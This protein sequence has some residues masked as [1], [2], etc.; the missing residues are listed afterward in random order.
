ML[1][2]PSGHS[3]DINVE[4]KIEMAE[5][6]ITVK[7][8]VVAKSGNLLATLTFQN[9]SDKNVYLDK[10]TSCLLD[11]LTSRVFEIIGQDGAALE[12]VGI[13]VKRKYN[14]DDFIRVEPGKAV[15]TSVVLNKFYTFPRERQEYSVV[16]KVLNH[17]Y[18]D[19]QGSFELISNKI[20]VPQQY[21]EDAK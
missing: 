3:A 1:I 2:T 21:L 17:S 16:Y 7:L 6:L 13:M 18:E 15:S 4:R 14:R 8:D 19:I 12:Y 10:Y 11:Q 9:V 5:K 20:V